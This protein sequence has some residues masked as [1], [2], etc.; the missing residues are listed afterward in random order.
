MSMT[1]IPGFSAEASLHKA[2]WRSRSTGTFARSDKLIYPAQSVTPWPIDVGG[3]GD[4]D[5]EPSRTYGTV[6]PV[7]EDKF[8]ACVASCRAGGRTRTYAD[9]WRS[10]CKQITGFQTC[11]IA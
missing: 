8:N 1:D 11:V 5:T 7:N 3:V 4:L 10:C 2:T 6:T 9:C